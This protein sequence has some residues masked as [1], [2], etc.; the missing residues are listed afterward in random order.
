[1]TA[2]TDL[3]RVAHGMSFTDVLAVLLTV[4]GVGDQRKGRFLIRDV[5]V[6]IK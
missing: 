5:E 3:C 6:N 2:V 1:M 4:G